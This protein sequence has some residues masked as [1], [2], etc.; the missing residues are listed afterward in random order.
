M[1][2]EEQA[3]IAEAFI[4]L[5]GQLDAMASLLLALTV[6]VCRAN[7]RAQKKIEEMALHHNLQHAEM[8]QGQGLATQ[9][10]HMQQQLEVL[11]QTVRL[12]LSS[13]AKK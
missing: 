9:A 11:L 6:T 7:P 5:N 13:D 4:K 10:W 12:T 1:D 2:E 8:V 3:R